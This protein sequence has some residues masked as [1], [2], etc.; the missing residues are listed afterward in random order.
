MISCI[1]FIEHGYGKMEFSDYNGRNKM[2]IRIVTDSTADIPSSLVEELGIEVVPVIVRF[3]NQEFR[4]G[5][6]LTSNEFYLKLTKSEIHPHTS[7][8]SPEDFASVFRELEPNCEGIVS[9]NI[10]AKLSGTVNSANQ[11]KLL[12]YGKCPIEV[13]DSRFNS[14]GLGLIVIQAAKLARAGESLSR[15]LETI[16]LNIEKTRMLGIFDTMK[17]LVRGGRVSSI[18]A[19]AARILNVKPI[20]TFLDGEVVQAGL[21]RSYDRGINK[22]VEFVRSQGKIMD[23]AIAHSAV[24]ERV[25][26]LKSRLGELFP[27]DNI[28]VAELGPAL[29]VHGGPGVLLVALRKS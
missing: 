21:V 13:V 7:Q 5:V 19:S 14:I 28:L 26:Q 8:P 4:S 1:I 10:S 27:I 2:T 9:I 22:I 17:Y 29:G 25:A 11:G 6:D 16:K 24:P 20:L 3:G 18:R 12:A 15:I 23:L